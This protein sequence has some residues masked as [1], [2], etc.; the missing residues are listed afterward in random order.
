VLDFFLYAR[1]DKVKKMYLAYLH[2]EWIL[3]QI[4]DFFLFL[5]GGAALAYALKKRQS[6]LEAYV[7]IGYVAFT[8]ICTLLA[9]SRS[10][11]LLEQ[12]SRLLSLP[13]IKVLPCY[14]SECSLSL[15]RAFLSAW[16]NSAIIYFLV[17]WLTPRRFE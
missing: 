12:I 15:G 13:W 5:S 16:L 3:F 7:I 10:L 4:F 11:I 6:P 2:G 17:A 9:I 1:G 14:D 8:F